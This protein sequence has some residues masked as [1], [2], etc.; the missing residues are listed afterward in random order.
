MHDFTFRLH[1]QDS[2][3]SCETVDCRGLTG[4]T[5]NLWEEEGIWISRRESEFPLF[6]AAVSTE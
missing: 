1:T 6:Y 5:D 3:F 2:A 4:E